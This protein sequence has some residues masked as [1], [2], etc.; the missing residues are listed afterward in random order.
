[1][2]C[3]FWANGKQAIAI[4]AIEN[5]RIDALPS[6]SIIKPDAIGAII[7]LIPKH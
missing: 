3:I 4:I 5:Q 6:R 1:M 2:V 7:E